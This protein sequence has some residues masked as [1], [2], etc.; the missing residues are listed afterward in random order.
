MRHLAVAVAIALLS[1]SGLLAQSL[2]ETAK[3]NGGK[4]ESFISNNIPVASIAD[5]AG[6]ADLVVHGSIGGKLAHLNEDESLVVTDYTVVPTRIFK[7]DKRNTARSTPGAAVPITVRRSGGTVVDGEYR[8]VTMSDGYSEREDFTVGE[9]T[10]LFLSYSES[11]RIYRFTAGPFGAFRVTNGKVV[12]MIAS[13]AKERGDQPVS[14][15][16][17]LG[18]VQSYVTKR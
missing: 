13:V 4:A 3:R 8:Y 11:E 14:L 16:A 2:R 18:N 12:P 5:V 15:G 10:V 17:F 9:E 6:H 7:T 1:S